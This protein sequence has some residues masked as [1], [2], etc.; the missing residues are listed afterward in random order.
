MQELQSSQN[1]SDRAWNF[2]HNFPPAAAFFAPIIVFAALEAYSAFGFGGRQAMTP[3]L[4]LFGSVHS[5]LKAENKL[6]EKLNR[7][8]FYTFINIGFESIDTPTLVHI[9]KPVDE[10]KVRES[11]EKMLEINAAYPNLEVTGNFIM[12][13]QLPLVHYQSLSEFLHGATVPIRGKGAIYLSPLKDSSKKRELLP[14][15]LEIKKQSKIPIFIYLIQR[16]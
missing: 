4:F 5:L 11:F 8:P 15:F 6:L 16:L 7:L 2:T 9:G 1:G 10:S 14:R 12:G 3:L 13:E